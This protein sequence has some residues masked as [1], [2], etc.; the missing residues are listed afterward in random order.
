MALLLTMPQG[1]GWQDVAWRMAVGGFGFGFFQ[2]PNNRLLI[3][4][5][6]P[7]RSGAA[8]GMMSTARL[9]GQTSGSAIVAL[10]FGVASAAGG[11]IASGV[12][13]SL[14]AGLIAAGGA[15]LVSFVRLRQL[16]ERRP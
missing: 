5:A 14:T 7:E 16:Q 11:G 2:S 8:S 13:L 1:A 9:L 6:P 10:M 4:A 15:T 3:G 12:R